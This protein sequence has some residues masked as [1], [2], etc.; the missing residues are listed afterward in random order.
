MVPSVFCVYSVEILEVQLPP[1]FI[2]LFCLPGF[3]PTQNYVVNKRQINKNE[4]ATIR[5]VFLAAVCKSILLGF[6]RISGPFP[7]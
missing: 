6:L 7:L 4:L 3:K 5:L 2:A 1:L